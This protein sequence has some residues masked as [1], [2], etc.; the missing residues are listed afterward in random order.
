MNERIEMNN[1][2]INV[3]YKYEKA[4]V[5]A[6]TYVNGYEIKASGDSEQTEFWA[7]RNHLNAELNFRL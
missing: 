6:I 3:K 7:L 2:I 1:Q 5:W 4:I